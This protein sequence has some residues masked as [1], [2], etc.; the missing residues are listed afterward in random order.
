MHVRMPAVC[1]EIKGRLGS[2]GQGPFPVSASDESFH[3]HWNGKDDAFSPHNSRFPGNRLV[4]D[5]WEGNDVSS[6]TSHLWP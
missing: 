5:S 6:Y 1:Q 2:A 4:R 3:F